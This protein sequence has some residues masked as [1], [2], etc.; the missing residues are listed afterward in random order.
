MSLDA[1]MIDWVVDEVHDS[2]QH[3]SSA[4]QEYFASPDDLTAL[5]FAATHLHQAQGTLQMAELD[6]AAALL[7]EAEML[8]QA[9]LADKI[10]AS[11]S[12]K[13]ELLKSI[14]VVD[15]CIT[16]LKTGRC[17]DQRVL[18]EIN[19]LRDLQGKP[20]V[21]RFSFFRPDISAYRLKP[22]ES[23]KQ[24]PDVKKLHRTLQRGLLLWLQRPED[25]SPL[26]ELAGILDQLEQ[27]A[28]LPTLGLLWASA[29]AVCESLSIGGLE[30]TPETKKMLG[31]V[32]RRLKRFADDGQRALLRDNPE[33]LIRAL[34]FD[35]V[36]AENPGGRGEA[37]LREMDLHSD[38]EP[39]A[40]A[41]DEGQLQRLR[42][43]QRELESQVATARLF[44]NDYFDPAH[45][46]PETLQ[47]LAELLD[48][49]RQIG[50]KD[51]AS[52]QAS[53]L[54]GL[55][56]ALHEVCQAYVSGQVG[57]GEAVALHLAEGLLVLETSARDAAVNFSG[58][59]TRVE[60]ATDNLERL[61]DDVDHIEQQ[62]TR[63]P[64][65]T[66]TE[67]HDLLKAVADEVRKN[68]AV[69]EQ[70]VTRFSEKTSE[71]DAL[72]PAQTALHEIAGAL[73]MLDRKG[74][75]QL[76]GELSQA[77]AD[78]RKG[79][80][81]PQQLLLESIALSSGAVEASVAALELERPDV[82]ALSISALED[83]RHAVSRAE[84]QKEQGG[85]WVAEVGEYLGQWL[86]KPDDGVA[87]EKLLVALEMP[88]GKAYS[89]ETG[90]IIAAVRQAGEQPESLDDE[91][92]RSVRSL[93]QN[94][95]QR[96]IASVD[97]G[98][99]ENK[100]SPKRQY[101]EVKPPTI[102]P[103][104]Q[105]VFF[106]EAREHLKAINEV[107]KL[108]TNAPIRYPL[109]R[110]VHALAGAS[111]ALGLTSMADA[112]G[113]IETLLD[114]FDSTNREL[115]DT[116]KAV[117]IDYHQA[118]LGLLKALKGKAS[119]DEINA[120]FGEINGLVKGQ[121]YGGAEESGEAAQ[122]IRERIDLTDVYR[123]EVRQLLTDFQ[124]YADSWSAG[125]KDD[126]PLRDMIRVMHT[127]KGGAR[128]TDLTNMANLAYAA[129]RFLRRLDHQKIEPS[130]GL[131]DLLT[132]VTDALHD[133]AENIGKGRGDTDYADL[134]AQLD[135]S[136]ENG[137]LGAEHAA[138]ASVSTV[139]QPEA[140]ASE[141]NDEITAIFLDEADDIL[142][143]MDATLTRLD[144]GDDA[145]T[146]KDLKR[147]FHTLKGGARMVGLTELGDL[148]H[149]VESMLQAD[150]DQ[151]GSL[152]KR[153][154]SLLHEIRTEMIIAME[155]VRDGL[156]PSL[157][158]VAKKV[159]ELTCA[160]S[161][162]EPE[163]VASAEA[164][165]PETVE[166]KASEVIETVAESEQHAASLEKNQNKDQE[167][168]QA[169]DQDAD[170]K[171]SKAGDKSDAESALPATAEEPEKNPE[172]EHEFQAEPGVEAHADLPA[173]STAVRVDINTL[174]TLVNLTSEL[175][176]SRSRMRLQ[177]SGFVGFLDEM[178]SVVDRFQTYFRDFE[179]EAE[180]AIVSSPGQELSA[181]SAEFDP[182]ELDRF[183]RL[184]QL[185]RSLSEC[186]DD[187][188]NIESGME[189][190]VWQ[191]ETLFHNDS[192]IYGKLHEGLLKTRMQPVGILAGRL[193]HLVRTISV[194]TGKKVDL[195]LLGQ[196]V[197]LD[198][199]ILDRMTA[200][201]EH[202][203]RNAL[204]HGIE[205]PKK[206]RQLGKPENGKIRIEFAQVY[207]EVI[208]RFSDD[209][210]G[211]NMYRLRERAVAAGLADD[212]VD[213]HELAQLV[214]ESGVS[215]SDS[216]TQLSGRGV[217]MEV[218]ASEIRYLGG[219]IDVETRSGKGV[220]FV[221]NIPL[222][223]S[224][225]RA[226]LVRCAG[227]VLAIPLSSIVQVQA[228]THDEQ[229]RLGNEQ[230]PFIRYR[231]K[232]Y[233]YSSLAKRLGFEDNAHAGGEQHVLLI[234]SGK[235]CIALGVDE[236]LDT[237]DC[238]IKPLNPQISGVRSVTGASILGSGDVALLLDPGNLRRDPKT[239]SD[240]DSQKEDKTR[241]AK[242]Q[243]KPAVGKTP[244]S[245]ARLLI[246]DDSVTV[247]KVTG[248]L[249]TRNG[250]KVDL[251]RDGFD[252][253]K[254][255]EERKP[256]LM[257]I[258]IEM[259]KM[260][261][262]ELLRKIKKHP[263]LSHIPCIFITSRSGGK[264][265]KKALDL[266][267]VDYFSKPYDDAA[268]I[269]RINS[270][271]QKGTPT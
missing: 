54:E 230:R 87:R 156:S 24:P 200:P 140:V 187:L 155:S 243:R 238:V 55:L 129:E 71:R 66:D 8:I 190:V 90:Q 174:D 118:V 114:T 191:S 72:D 82:E 111:A 38:V 236:V 189:R 60:R 15:D 261:G 131:L 265:R 113:A 173:R 67:H 206:R 124:R 89:A 249:M 199:S 256:D 70:S 125:E 36:N 126:A 109:R 102:D 194:E 53:G 13:Q 204:V 41:I 75:A 84:K 270:I 210:A 18:A 50:A 28:E 158:T 151:G 224:M 207:N 79:N 76:A 175:G 223:L 228:L 96:S 14:L 178:Q 25:P 221:I 163:A 69:V 246:V 45:D 112:S 212:A 101:A 91:L 177:F 176:V 137:G 132:Q 211:I 65:P 100:P 46:D 29:A 251:A 229:V 203:I 161:A 146:M 51:D 135:N 138:S 149:G 219:H 154:L 63:A 240:A 167:E 44:L 48:D 120:R 74:I 86:D 116:Q 271:L 148:A 31:D 242:K 121:I 34:L 108:Q 128:V 93:F 183:S 123:D 68:L 27:V 142:R 247:R 97:A 245:G 2:L 11:D 81:A 157:Q 127:I 73:E 64:P 106:R 150:V 153:R 162:E 269:G 227:Q 85:N 61:L 164:A 103:E 171:V 254:V 214:L 5:R 35:L 202:M 145:D 258:D 110:A 139:A 21:S 98:S 262:Y 217:G 169:K 233:Y 47:P 39:A 184:Q 159:E 23:D 205:S 4:F 186:V 95:T 188:S 147:Q 7:T 130:Q 10:S 22:S 83:L 268:L 235:R 222:S 226:N 52:A 257:L 37:L 33:T 168:N 201:L 122:G 144:Q 119:W 26:T 213:D 59:R 264:H 225:T 42:D 181:S 99:D 252:A 208:M 215:T 105:K 19:A 165:L 16:Q 253:L 216:V 198:R 241:A 134:V 260:D 3:V 197:E 77:I 6:A 49:L 136:H 185:T 193:Q 250:F 62:A 160:K 12:F 220:T 133:S 58:W 266:G 94:I 9:L 182:L 107:C 248:R 152:D 166:D 40:D 56:D 92:I 218:V 267:A 30:A 196:D 231:N 141:G 43:I 179:M 57:S 170:N 20:A 104:V 255:L 32:E 192:R 239:D 234:R 237:E 1:V 263:D 115:D 232:K 244:A 143:D 180:T 117:L 209:G 78:I 17:D 259:P 195:E 80:L 172:P 88:E